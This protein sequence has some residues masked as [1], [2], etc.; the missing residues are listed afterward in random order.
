M[1]VVFPIFLLAAHAAGE[2]TTSYWFLRN[3]VVGTDRIKYVASV[4]DAEGDRVTLAMQPTNDP[5]YEG[6]PIQTER[7]FTYTF[8]STMFAFANSFEDQPSNEATTVNYDMSVQCEM[9]A[10]ASA[11]TC[12]ASYNEAHASLQ[13]FCD[14]P[15]SPYGP[16][17]MTRLWTFSDTD[18]QGVET[19]EITF[20]GS[21]TTPVPAFCT[22]APDA[23]V[24]SSELGWVDTVER[25]RFVTFQV[26]ITAG[27]EKIISAT[28]GGTVK[29]SGAEPTG[30]AAN[31]ESGNG[32]SAP[33]RTLTPA[34]AGLGAAA[35]IFL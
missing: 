1:R 12:T 18:T 25:D 5:D 26:V 24:P 10:T 33:M 13:A 21:P 19:I 31:E 16:T 3:A 34:L 23:P 15:T 17:T 7:A 28:A 9:Q 27:E 11:A 35:A 20:A 22:D 4:I 6:L 30:T 2:L 29:T 14:R 32:A 8:A